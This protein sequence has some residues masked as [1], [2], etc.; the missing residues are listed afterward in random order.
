MSSEEDFRRMLTELRLLEST[1]NALQDRIN[2]IRAA[3]T[4]LAFAFSTIEGLEKEK[5]GTP[6]LVPI[7]GGSFIKAEVATTQTMVVG[8]GAGVSVEKT[9][10][11]A[12]QILEKR[13]ADL[14][15]SRASLEQQLGQ[16]LDRMRENRQQLDAI[17]TKL[18][19]SGQP[20][21]VRKI[22]SRS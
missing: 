16:V 20:D 4:E 15:K 7:G 9:R 22:K 2:M 14:E 18:V 12:K 11:E 1:G 5:K 13:S 19:G 10:I 17:S 21:D 3:I 8:I 6:L